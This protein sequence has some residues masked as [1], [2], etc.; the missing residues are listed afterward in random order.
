VSVL[1]KEN[2]ARWILYQQSAYGRKTER[3]YLIDHFKHLPRVTSLFLNVL[4]RCES[5]LKEGW[6]IIMNILCNLR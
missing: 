4:M 6:Y 2:A 3:K 1:V 5:C